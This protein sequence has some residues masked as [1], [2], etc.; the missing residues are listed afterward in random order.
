M[1]ARRTDDFKSETWREKG[2]NLELFERRISARK[3]NEKKKKKKIARQEK[4]G[5]PILPTFTYIHTYM[6]TCIHAYSN[7]PAGR[8]SG[9]NMW[10][11]AFAGEVAMHIAG[12]SALVALKYMGNVLY[13]HIPYVFAKCKEREKQKES[14]RKAKKKKKKKQ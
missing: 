11:Q 5:P 3:R 14:K 4:K 12:E 7:G 8:K 9:E 2:G 6:H 10:G 1:A 13:I